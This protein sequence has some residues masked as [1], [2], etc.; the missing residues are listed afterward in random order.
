MMDGI[1]PA[2]LNTSLK[3]ASSSAHSSSTLAEP[4]LPLNG[5]E[6]NP[7]SGSSLVEFITGPLGGLKLRGCLHELQAAEIGRKVR[8]PAFVFSS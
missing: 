5:V 6:E 7:S 1:E 4:P 3:A 2:H 8:S